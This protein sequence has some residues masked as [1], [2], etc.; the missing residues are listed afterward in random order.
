MEPYLGKAH[1][2]QHQRCQKW[3][4]PT[5]YR[6]PVPHPTPPSA[7]G[8][9]TDPIA[10]PKWLGWYR[11]E[12]LSA[13]VAA[14]TH[15]RVVVSS[16]GDA[17]VELPIEAELIAACRG[18]TGDD[19]S[20]I[21]HHLADSHADGPDTGSDPNPTPD[22][23][24]TCNRGPAKG[25]RGA[26]RSANGP[27][28]GDR[29]EVPRRRPTCRIGGGDDS[30]GAVGGD[31]EVDANTGDPTDGI[32]ARTRRVTTYRVDDRPLPGCGPTGGVG[33][34]AIWPAAPAATHRDVVGH[35]TVANCVRYGS[36]A[37]GQ[38]TGTQAL[39]PPP[40]SV[41]TSMFDTSWIAIHNDT[42]GHE[43][44]TKLALLSPCGTHADGPPVGLVET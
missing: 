37:L 30:S 2:D 28:A 10:V 31:T 36:A 5:T 20:G 13:M 24:R 7:H 8:S 21:G 17:G 44:L 34:N 15:F 23:C 42:D 9:S 16:V 6:P 41:E 27:H 12:L 38:L 4:L 32:A 19:H 11:A 40:G 29:V 33:G 43:T 26:R 35:D 14:P 1:H 18:R 22:G 3:Q 25:R 39:L